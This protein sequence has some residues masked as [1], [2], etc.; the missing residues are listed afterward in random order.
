MI[1]WAAFAHDVFTQRLTTLVR[2]DGACRYRS[3]RDGSNDGSCNGIIGRGSPRRSQRQGGDQSGKNSDQHRD[4]HAASGVHY[5][6]RVVALE[7]SQWIAYRQWPP[8]V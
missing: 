1:R 2:N 8:E 7:S 5:S 6:S 4:L 3:A